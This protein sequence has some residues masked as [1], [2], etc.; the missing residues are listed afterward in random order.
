MDKEVKYTIRLPQ[1]IHKQIEE[2]ASKNRRS[3][4]NEMLVIFESFIEEAKRIAA[5]KEE[6]LKLNKEEEKVM[7][8]LKSLP[9]SERQALVSKILSG[10]D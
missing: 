2:L 4:N 5:E 9:L 3:I 7:D 1:E 10:Q 6:S 8:K